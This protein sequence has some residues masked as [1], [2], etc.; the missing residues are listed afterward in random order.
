[1][2]SRER[3]DPGSR[4]Y[5]RYIMK[6]YLKI[7]IRNLIRN[8]VSGFVIIAGFAFSLAV[9][10]LLA[11]YIFNESDYDKSF[12]E[13]NR[14]YRLCAEKGITTFRGDKIQELK[15]RYPEIEM[16]CR[17]DNRSAEVVHEKSP[18]AIANLVK[19]DNDFFKIFS[20]NIR[21]GNKN[22][23]LPDNNSLAISSSL[24][25]TIFGNSDP[26]GKTI[27]IQHRKDF[28]IS[29]VYDDLPVNSSIQAQA[30]IT[31]ENVNDLGGEWRRGI[32]YSRYFLPAER[33]K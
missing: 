17:Y 2:K 26:V 20:L 5:I 12:P 8:P 32:Y 14:I 10:L 19:T 7:T 27:S 11:S 22:E 1:M 31:W 24:A 13:I 3:S 15:D 18:F 25:R 6:N 16:I 28:I 30:V 29:A 4:L 33:K 21:N 9:A 23:P